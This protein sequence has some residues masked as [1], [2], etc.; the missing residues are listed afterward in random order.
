M[1]KIGDIVEVFNKEYKIEKILHCEYW[2]NYGYDVE[3]IDTKGIYHH[4]KQN[5]DGGKLKR[6]KPQ[7]INASNFDGGI[8][9]D[10]GNKVYLNCY[11]GDCTDLLKKY[12]ML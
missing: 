6:I 10:K 1:V 2:D 4:W 5:L 11:G 9:Y 12:G 7:S 3:F 8:Y